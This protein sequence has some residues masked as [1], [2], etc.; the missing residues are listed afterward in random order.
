[1][2]S[3]NSMA[4]GLDCASPESIMDPNNLTP[5]GD[6][7]SLGCVLYYC[8]TGRY[9]FPEGSAV[10]K[11]MAHQTKE[12][13]AVADLNP[14]VPPELAAVIEKLMA[15]APEARYADAQEVIAALEPLAGDAPVAAPRPAAER[16]AAPVLSD[17]PRPGRREAALADTVRG[18]ERA[19]P[20][21]R[22]VPAPAPRPARAARD[23]VPGAAE[24]ETAPR[25][26]EDRLG[27]I[28]IALVAVLACAV[29]WL[30]TWKLF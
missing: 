4:S 28:G 30:V 1:M 17:T 23:P 20:P 16:R 10:E 2:S 25:S 9:P 27:P 14:D 8:V 18:G 3:A 15:K 22:P 21:A 11:M 6:Q 7:Y 19:A 5:R 29:A 12:P 24:P 26:W 13:E